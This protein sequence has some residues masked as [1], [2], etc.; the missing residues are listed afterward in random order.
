[1]VGGD[2]VMAR[3]LSAHAFHIWAAVMIILGLL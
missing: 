1:M 2:Q 3:F